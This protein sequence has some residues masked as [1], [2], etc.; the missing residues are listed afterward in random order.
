MNEAGW[1][2]VFERSGAI[3]SGH[4]ELTSGL[5]S[6]LYVQK[7]RVLEHP[8]TAMALAREIVSW[9]QPGGI[10]VVVAR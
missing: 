3:L 2:E 4:F 10:D 8:E 7:A 6:D 9:Y 1:R 5:H